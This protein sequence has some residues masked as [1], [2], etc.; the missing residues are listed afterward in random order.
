MV[1]GIV[2][3]FVPGRCCKASL[4]IHSAAPFHPRGTRPL[5]RPTV[6]TDGRLLGGRKAAEWIGIKTPGRHPGTTGGHPGTTGGH[7][8]TDRVATSAGRRQESRGRSTRGHQGRRAGTSH[9]IPPPS[10]APALEA[11]AH[12]HAYEGARAVPRRTYPSTPVAGRTTNA[13]PV[14]L[15][16]SSYRPATTRNRSRSS[17]ALRFLLLTGHHAQP[18]PPA[19]RHAAKPP[20]RS[21]C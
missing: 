2:P 14:P 9:R 1:V 16:T 3:P 18:L 15:L 7:R 13:Q 10:R 19:G 6:E 17:T 11:R 21:L 20:S 4:P 5:Q 12:P 8:A